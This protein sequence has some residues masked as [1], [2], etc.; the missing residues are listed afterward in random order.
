MC[1]IAGVIA[2]EPAFPIDE[3]PLR[4]AAGL[5][6]HRGP[7]GSNVWSEP[8][9]GLSH[10]RLAIIDRARGDQPMFSQDGRYVVVFNGEIYNHHDLRRE[11]AGRGYRLVT[12]CDTE[13]LLYLYDWL[14]EDMVDR[15]RGMF[16]FAVFDRVERRALL[17]RDRFGK[18]PLYYA[19]SGGALRF[20]STLDAMRVLLPTSLDLDVGAIAQYLVL[21][22]VPS[23]LSPFEGVAKL[24]PGHLATWADGVLRVRQ[25]WQPPPRAVGAGVAD[26]R[27]A[28]ERVRELIGEA[29][30]IRLESEVP[31]GVFLS[32]GLDSSV[33]VAEM[34]AAG[35]RPKTYSM[36][37]RHESFD[38]TR[39]A[40]LVAEKFDTDH[41]ELEADQDAESMFRD[42]VT[43]YDEPFADSS[44]LATLAVAKAAAEHVTVILTGDGG[45][46]LFGGYMRYAG[47]R[48]A[49]RIRRVLGP[50][51]PVAGLTAKMAGH[52]LHHRRLVAGGRFIQ[53]PWEGYRDGLFYFD[54]AE[55][56]GIL[57]PE[58]MAKVN[59]LA[60]PDRLDTLWALGPSSASSLLWIDQQT[61]LP[62]DLLTKMDRATMAHS[63]EARSPLLD[64]VLAENCA[65]LPEDLLFDGPEGKSI[66][67]DAYAGVLPPEILHRTKMGFGVPIAEW[68]RRELQPEVD[69]LLLSDTGPLWGLLRKEA[70]VAGVRSFLG[71]GGMQPR[72]VWNL[73]AV[74]GWMRSRSLG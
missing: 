55:L 32:G 23:P 52:A 66:L 21:Q 34:A 33:V 10:T 45:D 1:G 47:F 49:M 60:P 71:S 43:Y 38:E 16:A 24:S 3:G 20:A 48:R 14:R 53:R 4:E 7:D 17:A 51:A 42:L 11:L 36:G 25:Y 40:R 73:L 15:L 74:A 18:K 56:S 59:A 29:V 26:R 35:I 8:G 6:R 12:R 28:A 39:Y 22:Y 68:M 63:L 37:F 41:H 64:Q 72:C 19:Q 13:V 5:L 50:L 46:E 69:D 2:A 54:P 65:E 67:R 70:V 57:R 30:R 61:Y 58:V 62:D 44:A 9:V 27:E 31:L